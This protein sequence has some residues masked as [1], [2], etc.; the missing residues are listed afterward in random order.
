MKC[1]LEMMDATHLKMHHNIYVLNAN[2]CTCKS[3]YNGNLYYVYFITIEKVM[4]T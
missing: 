2:K 1:V 4:H 3:G